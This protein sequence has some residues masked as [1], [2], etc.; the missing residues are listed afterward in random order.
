M[1]M[2]YSDLTR[3]STTSYPKIYYPDY[4]YEILHFKVGLKEAYPSLVQ[5]VAPTNYTNSDKILGIKIFIIELFI[6]FLITC[7]LIVVLH[8]VINI[9]FDQLT[10]KSYKQHIVI[11]TKII[12]ICVPI[13]IA[14]LGTIYGVRNF[15][16]AEIYLS[17]AYE[18]G[19]IRYQK[20]NL[21]YKEKE[22]EVNSSSFQKQEKLRILRNKSVENKSDIIKQSQI[23]KDVDVK[24]GITEL[25]FHDYLI[26]YSNFKIYKSLKF[27]YYFPDLV[28]IDESNFLVI[29]IEIDE[30]YIFETREPIHYSDTDLKRDIYFTQNNFIV[31]RFAEE[32][33]ITQPDYC[34][35]VINL[36]INSIQT[37]Q[38]PKSI[39]CEYTLPAWNYE[40]AFSFAYNHSRKNLDNLV[41]RARIQYLEN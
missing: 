31:I 17:K 2:P 41:K 32:Q 16:E 8:V 11:A 30:P 37:L 9:L 24:K 38:E 19:M 20:Q 10:L 3:F 7:L 6:S 14:T 35:E 12:L 1:K 25:F 4:Y 34:L 21:I 40:D 36:I 23:L 26:K 27:G 5:P 28:I 18:Q 15:R 13:I 39:V 29:D 33:I 22:K